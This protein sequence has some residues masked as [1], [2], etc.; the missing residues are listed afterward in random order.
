MILHDFEITGQSLRDVSDD[1]ILD[2]QWRNENAVSYQPR[3]LH[4]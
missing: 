2:Q 3:Y 4:R 1:F